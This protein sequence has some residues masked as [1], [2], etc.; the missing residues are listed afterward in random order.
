MPCFLLPGLTGEDGFRPADISLSCGGGTEVYTGNKDVECCGRKI[1]PGCMF[2]F[3][4]EGW[5]DGGEWG[6][7]LEFK[8]LS[9]YHQCSQLCHHGFESLDSSRYLPSGQRL[10]SAAQNDG[11]KAANAV[12]VASG[13][14]WKMR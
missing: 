6:G 4:R 3:L 10:V 11:C 1:H 13:N 7:T 2:I 9:T 14:G 12:P 5:P 8:G